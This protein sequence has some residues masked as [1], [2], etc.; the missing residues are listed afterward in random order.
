MPHRIQVCVL[1]PILTRYVREAPYTCRHGWQSSPPQRRLPTSSSTSK[2]NSRTGPMSPC[3]VLL[4]DMWTGKTWDIGCMSIIALFPISQSLAS[5][6]PMWSPIP[7]CWRTIVSVPKALTM[8]WM[9]SACL[10]PSPL[11][12]RSSWSRCALRRYH[13]RPSFTLP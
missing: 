13:P 10:C 1:Q 8:Q 12:S 5:P 2:Q 4:Q 9:T 3:T 11:S 7:W 6:R